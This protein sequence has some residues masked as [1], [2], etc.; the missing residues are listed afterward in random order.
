[1]DIVN[2]FTPMAATGSLSSEKLGNPKPKRFKRS[3]EAPL[4]KSRCRR[5]VSL[6][7]RLF[8]FKKTR[9]SKILEFVKNDPAFA[10]DFFRISPQQTKRKIHAF[11]WFITSTRCCAKIAF[12]SRYVLP[13]RNQCRLWFRFGRARTGLSAKFFDMFGIKFTG[14]PDLRRILMDERWQGYP[15]RKIIRLR[16]SAFY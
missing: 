8:S 6:T 3:S 1:M 15:L 4:K 14:H 7:C 9:S 13:S 16:L 10:Y 5:R 2:R 12:D 11:T